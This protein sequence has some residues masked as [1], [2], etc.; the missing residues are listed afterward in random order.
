MERLK[1]ES[2]KPESD[3]VEWRVFKG[4]FQPISVKTEN[5]LHGISTNEIRCY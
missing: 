5:N 2:S 1:D 3:E 4:T